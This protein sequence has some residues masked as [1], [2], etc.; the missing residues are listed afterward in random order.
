M[1]ASNYSSNLLECII[2]DDEP[3]AR[4]LME[5][6]CQKSGRLSIK[7]IFFDALAAMRFLEANKIDVLF[8][9]IH[10]PEISGLAML[11]SLSYQPKV[12]FTTAFSEHSLEAFNF[13]VVDYL[14]KPVRFERFLKAINKLN[15]P[16]VEMP[17]PLTIQFESAANASI[18]PDNVL[19]VEAF[20]NYL[21]VHTSNKVQLLHE[22][23]E[24]PIVKVANTCW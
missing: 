21:K 15:E 9:D 13:H 6:Y 5:S 10:L 17:L 16:L 11:Q 7:G 14:L 23:F 2:V 4:N 24:K 12:I 1:P 22:S 20:G 8:L 18:Q 19:Y 3:D